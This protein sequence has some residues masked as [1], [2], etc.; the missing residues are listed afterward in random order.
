MINHLQ[1][2]PSNDPNVE[3][4]EEMLRKVQ[5][6]ATS[7]SLLLQ[8]AF[9]VVTVGVGGCGSGGVSGCGVGGWGVWWLCGI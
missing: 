2:P 7:K 9:E 5:Q 8:E 1:D 3:E 6:L 4:A